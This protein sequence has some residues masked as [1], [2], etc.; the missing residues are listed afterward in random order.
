MK[1][2]IRQALEASG[3]F[4]DRIELRKVRGGWKARLRPGRGAWHFA[5]TDVEAVAAVRNA[6]D[7]KG[8]LQAVGA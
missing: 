4:N 2:Y 3:L 6:H 1:T 5:A 8:K 7:V